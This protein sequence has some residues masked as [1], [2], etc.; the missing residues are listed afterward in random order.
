MPTDFMDQD[1]G[2]EESSHGSLNRPG[3]RMSQHR[4]QVARHVTGANR[5]IELLRGRQEA[6]EKERAALED[7]KQKQERYEEGKREMLD[8]LA[9]SVVL[10]QKEQEQATRMAELLSETRERFHDMLSRLR[11]IDENAWSDDT[12]ETE[13][14]QALSAVDAMRDDYNKAL[15]RIDASSWHKTEGKRGLDAPPRPLTGVA[16][17]DRGFLGWMKVG[18]AVSLPTI[19]ALVLLFVLHL[20]LTGQFGL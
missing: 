3:D 20:Y 10:V 8:A 14:T 5:E 18:I 6:L 12:F 1:L 11:K 15:A 7:L 17:G 16:G 9:R 4:E 19:V 2:R 13:L